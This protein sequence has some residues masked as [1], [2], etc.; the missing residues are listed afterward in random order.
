MA[1]SQRP[2]TPQAFQEG[3]SA[4]WEQKEDKVHPQSLTD[5]PLL[6]SSWATPALAIQTKQVLP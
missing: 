2:S 4:R 3:D 1:R 5:P 6:L